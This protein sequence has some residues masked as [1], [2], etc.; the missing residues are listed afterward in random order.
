MELNKKD[1]VNLTA[2]HKLEVWDD[3]GLETRRKE[4]FVL[5]KALRRMGERMEWGGGGGWRADSSVT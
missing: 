3:N 4:R 2:V 1:I 5:K